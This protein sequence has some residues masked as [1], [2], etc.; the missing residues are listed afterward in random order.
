MLGLSSLKQMTQPDRAFGWPD[1]VEGQPNQ[2]DLAF[3]VAPAAADL[4]GAGVPRL[5]ASGDLDQVFRQGRA[6]DNGSLS[7]HNCRD[8]QKTAHRCHI[9][10]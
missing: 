3:G 4:L 8:Q 5:P 2:S 9:G 6:A 1:L 7:G 10:R